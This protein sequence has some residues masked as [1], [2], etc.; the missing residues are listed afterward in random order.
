MS[1]TLDKA[2]DTSIYG[3]HNS[4]SFYTKTTEGTVPEYT[5]AWRRRDM[6]GV[7][8]TP[9]QSYD[10]SLNYLTALSMFFCGRL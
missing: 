7:R 4:Q 6:Y 8:I 9:D 5:L 3:G 2:S 1:V 10:L